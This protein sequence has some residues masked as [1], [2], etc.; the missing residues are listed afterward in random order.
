MYHM[1]IY[2]EYNRRNAMRIERRRL[3]D[4]QDPFEMPDE[5][6]RAVYRFTRECAFKLIEE[7]SPHMAKGQ[8]K[9]FVPIPLRICTALHFF[10]TGSFQRDVGQDFTAALSRTM[11]SRSVKEVSTVLQNKLMPKW[12]QF[13]TEEEYEAIKLRF[14]EETGFPGVIGAVDC[15]HIRIKRPDA[16]IECAYLNRKSYHSKNVQLANK[17]TEKIISIV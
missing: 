7:M 5:Q 8:R 11:V 14:F 9:T 12:I 2:D 15:T 10:A 4:A 3:R 17:L 1:V 6:F 16:E 13:P